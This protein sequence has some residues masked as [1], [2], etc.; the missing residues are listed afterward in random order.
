MDNI[1]KYGNIFLKLEENEKNIFIRRISKNHLL[2]IGKLKPTSNI[3]QFNIHHYKAKD[4]ITKLFGNNYLIKMYLMNENLDNFDKFQA[5]T[6][7]E[8][9]LMEFNYDNITSILDIIMAIKPYTKSP[10]K[11]Q[12]MS[13][14][15]KLDLKKSKKISIDI[16]K[17]FEKHYKE[18]VIQPTTKLNDNG[19]IISYIYSN[20][21]NDSYLNEDIIKKRIYNTKIFSTSKYG[22]VYFEHEKQIRYDYIYYDEN[23]AK[24]IQIFIDIY[25]NYLKN[26]S[27]NCENNDCDCIKNKKYDKLLEYTSEIDMPN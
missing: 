8:N 4:L 10:T 27:N 17:E 15:E 3:F 21:Y 2:F 13:K 20:Q 1:I 22:I 12:I 7:S 19:D 14:L 24:N 16:I 5:S 9:F 26:C 25:N 23:S 6:I 11:S 18:N